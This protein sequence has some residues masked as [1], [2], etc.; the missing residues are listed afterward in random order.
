MLDLDVAR[1]EAEVT[2]VR[3]VA[4]GLLPRQKS[5]MPP[6]LAAADAI[7]ARF[8]TSLMTRPD[9]DEVRV[10]LAAAFVEHVG[11]LWPAG[12]DAASPEWIAPNVD[13]VLVTIERLYA[14]AADDQRPGAGEFLDRMAWLPAL[15]QRL[16][17]PVPR[18]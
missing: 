6:D 17:Q 12:R 16:D 5:P 15:L 1:P 18:D 14:M 13:E 8:R 7:I 4:T 11:D 2:V 3:R 9:R 10:Q